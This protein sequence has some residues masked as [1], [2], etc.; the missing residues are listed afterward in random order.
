MVND[1]NGGR[2]VGSQIP[3]ANAAVIAAEKLRDYL[4]NPEHPHGGP[5]A[6]MLL[7][8]GYLADDW[9]LLADD[10]RDQH[11]TQKVARIEQNSYGTQFVIVAEL[12]GPIGDPVM[13]RSVW[14]IDIGTAV[15]RFITMYPE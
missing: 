1:G 8:M 4:L 11:L 12:Q 10:L 2:T 15:P 5:K 6:I 9:L 7:G 14:Q 3:N 13:F